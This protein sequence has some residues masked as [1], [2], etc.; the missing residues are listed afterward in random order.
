MFGNGDLLVEGHSF[1]AYS[2][3]ER[4]RIAL[5]LTGRLGLLRFGN[6]D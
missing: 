6:A 1:A 5:S 4:E 3:A 2:V